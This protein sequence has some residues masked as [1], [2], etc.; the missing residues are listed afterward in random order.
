MIGERGGGG[1]GFS[2]VG[3]TGFVLARF[4]LSG[5]MMDEHMNQRMVLMKQRTTPTEWT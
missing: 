5:A 4:V 1:E 3:L 2:L